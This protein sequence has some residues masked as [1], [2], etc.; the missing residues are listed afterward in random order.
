MDDL[1]LHERSCLNS[2]AWRRYTL[3]RGILD[4]AFFETDAAFMA[5][6]ATM[7][8][9][10]RF[11][12]P[13]TLEELSARR[14]GIRGPP[15]F[16]DM[17]RAWKYLGVIGWC[18]MMDEHSLVEDGEFQENGLQLGIREQ[19]DSQTI[20]RVTHVMQL[21]IPSEA[22]LSQGSKANTTSVAGKEGEAKKTMDQA[23]TVVS[24][25][26]AGTAPRTESCIEDEACQRGDMASFG[27]IKK[28]PVH[29][30]VKLTEAEKRLYDLS[31]MVL[32]PEQLANR[33][34]NKANKE[35]FEA[36]ARSYFIKGHWRKK[37]ITVAKNS[38]D[39]AERLGMVA[40]TRQGRRTDVRE[41]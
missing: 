9:Y 13:A 39:R 19:L 32:R 12:L 14:I 31:G 25:V 41:L 18:W 34:P 15:I 17:F 30:Q 3:V 20:E 16:P 21:S 22:T 29:K 1:A 38:G 36:A 7:A 37:K 6:T 28:R 26:P 33:L 11:L 2:Q 24:S 27:D 35:G 4:R 23:G 8:P 40:K 5:R 10:K